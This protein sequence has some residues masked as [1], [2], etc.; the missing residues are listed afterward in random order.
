MNPIFFRDGKSIDSPPVREQQQQQHV[1]PVAVIPYQQEATYSAKYNYT[2][3]IYN[4][5]NDYQGIAS[6]AYNP[7]H[8]QQPYPSQQHP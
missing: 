2:D 7:Q 8:L 6:P 5:A 4:G 1:G 3:P